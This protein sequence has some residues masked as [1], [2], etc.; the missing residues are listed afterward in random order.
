MPAEDDAGVDGMLHI[1]GQRL[2]PP[3]GKYWDDTE[4]AALSERP[5]EILAKTLPTASARPEAT[6]LKCCRA[7]PAAS[8]EVSALLDDEAQGFAACLLSGEDV[9]KSPKV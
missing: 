2:V 4:A 9:L 6:L 8:A 3:P 5:A 1:W 7:L